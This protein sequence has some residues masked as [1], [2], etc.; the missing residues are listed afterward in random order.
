MDRQSGVPVDTVLRRGPSSY[1]HRPFAERDG[2]TKTGATHRFLVLGLDGGT[3]ELLNPLMDAGELPFLRSLVQ[4]GISAPLRSVYPSKTIPAWYSFA[5]GLDPGALGIFG[6]TEPDGG[7]GKSRLVQGYR[8]HEALWDMLSRRGHRVGV[9]NF[10]VRAGYPINGYMIPGMFG[11]NPTTYPAD[12]RARVVDG[13]GEPLVAELPPYRES[14]RAEWLALAARGVLQRASA[15]AFLQE[16]FHPDFLFVLLRETDRVEH[17]H[18]AECSSGSARMGRDLLEF[19]RAVDRACAQIDAAF[20]AQ[21]EPAVTLV[22][23]DHGHG[24]AQAEFF[25]NRWLMEEG[26]LR[27]RPGAE[28]L[29]R[30]LL[31]RVLLA[32][33]RFGPTRRIVGTVADR[34]RAEEGSRQFD[35]WIGGDATFEAMANKIDW[36][37]TEAFSF[38]VPEAIYL[39]PYRSARS[40][41]DGRTTLAEIRRRLE[42]YPAAHIEVLEPQEIY[43]EIQSTVPPGL[44]LRVN[45]METDL[46]MDFSYPQSLLAK[47]PGYFYGSGVHR[48]DG[49]L[50]GAGNGSAHGAQ[51]EPL[52]LLDVAPTIL[53]GMGV[54]PPRRM[55][56][57]SFGAWLGTSTS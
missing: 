51:V 35:R 57:R 24:P 7:P 29:R 16:A 18:W 56:G 4:R 34:L 11:K 26:F 13:I 31:S 3:F 33:E 39:N 23:S 30:R 5:T 28:S 37:R 36:E 25:T 8:P 27:L 20:R 49:I 12:A 54:V 47:R 50:I 46:R 41:E 48:M 6:F 42:A 14:D 53:E 19:W 32:S 55:S 10:P 43:Q 1:P 9:L 21:G 45:E 17:Q 15:A 52:S 40:P 44:L 38:P 2:G 22:I